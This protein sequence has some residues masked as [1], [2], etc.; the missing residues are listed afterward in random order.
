MN[1]NYTIWKQET[2]TS[3]DAGSPEQFTFIT[4]FYTNRLAVSN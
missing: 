3:Y 1:N 4:L 2:N